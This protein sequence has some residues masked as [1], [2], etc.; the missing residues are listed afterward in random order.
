LVRQSLYSHA[1]ND[2]GYYLGRVNLAAALPDIEAD[3]SL[4]KSQVGVFVTGFFWAY[5]LGQLLYGQLGDR[6]SPRRFVFVGML[7]SYP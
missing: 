6:L 4:A 7:V 2:A 1:K 3:L 5:A